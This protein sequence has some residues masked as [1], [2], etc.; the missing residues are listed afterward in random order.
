MTDDHV[1]PNQTPTAKDLTPL[2]DALNA[3]LVTTGDPEH[4]LDRQTQILDQIFT[5]LMANKVAERLPTCDR[6]PETTM[7]WLALALKIQKQ[8]VDTTKAKA[9]IEYMNGL[10][11]N[12]PLD[13][14]E[15]LAKAGHPLK[16]EKRTNEH[17]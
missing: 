10:S 17:E 14:A 15:A 5:T 8:C 4:A 7:A 16:I 12:A 2:A 1:A 13:R 9:A 6:S 11:N 3:S